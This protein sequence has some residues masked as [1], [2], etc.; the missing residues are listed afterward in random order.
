[1]NGTG[2]VQWEVA[3]TSP[4]ETLMPS[5]VVRSIVGY[6]PDDA[7]YIAVK[8]PSGPGFYYLA[9]EAR[10]HRV[11]VLSGTVNSVRIQGLNTGEVPPTYL[12]PSDVTTIATPIADAAGVKYAV[13]GVGSLTELAAYA[14][15]CY[16][17]LLTTPGASQGL[18]MRDDSLTA[19]G[20]TNIAGISPRVWRKLV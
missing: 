2:T 6:T 5:G 16:L 14:G 8:T 10:Y 7:D 19:N 11:R 3:N 20:T 13:P 9:G 4:V 17:A 15:I 18:W 1:M 12:D